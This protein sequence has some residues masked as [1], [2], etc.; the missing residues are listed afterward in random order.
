MTRSLR[1]R[2]RRMTR[3]TKLSWIRVPQRPSKSPVPPYY[4]RQSQQ[5]DRLRLSRFRCRP[6]QVR[7]RL[8]EPYGSFMPTTL[9]KIY[10]ALAKNSFTLPFP[11]TRRSQLRP[12]VLYPRSYTVEAI[13]AL[14]HPVP[15]HSLAATPCMTHLLTG[16]EDGYIRDYDIFSAVNGKIFDC[17]STPPR[18]GGRRHPESWSSQIMVGESG[19]PCVDSGCRTSTRPQPGLAR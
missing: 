2:K 19:S 17:P 1:K 14:P 11:L 5:S 9:R 18:R 12:S 16:S 4:L 15:T 13:C 8:S 3:R 7:T 6:S 10:T